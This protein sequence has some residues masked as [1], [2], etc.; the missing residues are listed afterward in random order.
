VIIDMN[1]LL[2][3]KNGRGR[4]R[5]S[6]PGIDLSTTAYDGQ[7]SALFSATKNPHRIPVNTPPVFRSLRS[8]IYLRLVTNGNV[9]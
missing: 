4:S 3:A 5:R 2:A 8:R 1:I 6:L 7:A 9:G